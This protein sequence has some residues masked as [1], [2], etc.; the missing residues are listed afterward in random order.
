MARPGR[1]GRG[2]AGG[3]RAGARGPG[4]G[5]PG[6]TGVTGVT[7]V[8]ARA[9][10]REVQVAGGARDM[11]RVAQLLVG[12]FYLDGQKD[13][14]GMNAGQQQGLAKEQ[15]A[16]MQRRYLAKNVQAEAAVLY[17]EDD[18]TGDVVASVALGE[19]PF[20][21]GDALLS[22]RDLARPPPGAEFNP[23]L[24][25]LAV[26]K[27]YRKRGYGKRLVRECEGLAREWGHDYLWLLVEDGNV[28]AR[29]LYRKLGF[30]VVKKETDMPTFKVV[31]G[32]VQQVQVNNFYMK[33]SVKGG[34]AQLVEN[35]NWAKVGLALGAAAGLK[36]FAPEVKQALTVVGDATGTQEVVERVLGFL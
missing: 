22:T 18:A 4:G 34:V 32:R 6:V 8:R 1:W 29:N 2:R 25:N 20:L 14:G 17:L 31:N 36:A 13:G 7:G 21:Y 35:A 24:A 15:S 27:R 28:R 16:D 3:P 5:H 11:L 10:G 33:K 12:S 26:Q 23:V 30:K 9:V 19:T